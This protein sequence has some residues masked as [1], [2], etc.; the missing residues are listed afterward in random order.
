MGVPYTGRV[1]H[2]EINLSKDIQYYCVGAGFDQQE[3]P[4][5]PQL[6]Q[7]ILVWGPGSQECVF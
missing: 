4:Q 7:R 2:A 3:L 5:G 6:C 1:V